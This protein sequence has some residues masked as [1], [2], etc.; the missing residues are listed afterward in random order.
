M[1]KRSQVPLS[2][3]FNHSVLDEDLVQSISSQKVASKPSEE[4]YDQQIERAF[5][6]SV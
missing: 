4:D 6:A 3:L 1:A 5:D 2:K